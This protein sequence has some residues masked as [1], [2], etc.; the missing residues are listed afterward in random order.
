MKY[1]DYNALV[2]QCGV[3]LVGWMEGVGVC[4][5]DRINT[6]PQLRRL[7]TALNTGACHW[8]WLAPDDWAVRKAAHKARVD[9]GL[10]R[11][12]AVR[13]DKGISRKGKQPTSREVI[14]SSD[15][16]SDSEDSVDGA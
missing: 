4:P 10:D 16:S 8:E 12:R 6:A 13:K 15:D 3:Q 9:A 1:T 2:V 14:D 5:I 7:L 11:Q